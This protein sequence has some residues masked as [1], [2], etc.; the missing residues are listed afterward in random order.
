MNREQMENVVVT[1]KNKIEKKD[2]MYTV[3]VGDAT[4]LDNESIL[5]VKEK[6][7]A[8]NPG[9]LSSVQLERKGYSGAVT[10]TMAQFPSIKPLYEKLTEIHGKLWYIEDRKRQIEEGLPV[11]Q[12]L[13]KLMKT[14]NA[15]DLKEYLTLSRE[16]SLY[17]DERA[18]IKSE[19]N[20]ITG[21]K[22]VEVKSHQ[23]A[24]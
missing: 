15:S 13:E 24:N 2:G 17:N 4:L 16:V 9:K 22:I 5:S 10:E 11:D 21:S 14:E 1:P 12:V 18:K 23:T 19:M 6:N 7:F 8:D 20:K 3:P